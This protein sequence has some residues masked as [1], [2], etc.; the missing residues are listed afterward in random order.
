MKSSYKSA[1]SRL[2]PSLLGATAL[3]AGLLGMAAPAFAQGAKPAA[4]A[5][6]SSTGLAEIIVTARKTDE[7]LQDVPVSVTVFSGEQLKT[8]GAARLEDVAHFTPGLTLVG[9]PANT[10]APVFAVRGQAQ[11]DVLATLEPSVGVYVDGLYIA[12]TPG[13]NGDLLDIASVQTL[14]GPQGTL[15]GKNTSAGA[16]LFETNK[17]KLNE[18][19]LALS[20]T[21]GRFN[22]IDGSAVFNIPLVTDKLAFRGAVQERHRD[23]IYKDLL[24]GK[25]Y[26]NIENYSGR[27]KLLWEPSPGVSIVASGDWFSYKARGPVE[28]ITYV[29]PAPNA[30][31]AAAAIQAGNPGVPLAIGATFSCIVGS[32][33]PRPAGTPVGCGIPGL[34]GNFGL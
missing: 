17:P 22:Q 32:P 11:T 21:Y 27:A 16:I 4:E 6:E 29:S 19:S 12:R 2:V 7:K 8:Q 24:N 23:G 20:A 25:T 28:N 34:A 13:L 3:A 14:K 5:D 1:R 15:F 18:T 9:S 33:A 26:N 10:N 31:S 30:A